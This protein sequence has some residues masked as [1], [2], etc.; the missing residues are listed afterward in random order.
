MNVF[1]SAP[2]FDQARTRQHEEPWKTYAQATEKLARHFLT[3]PLPR[4]DSSRHVSLLEQIRVL[5]K[6]ILTLAGWYR[7]SHDTRFAEHAWFL[8]QEG[9]QWKEWNF[10]HEKFDLST[11]EMAMLLTYALD[12]LE[13]FLSPAQYEQVRA[14]AR[15]RIFQNYLQACPA[16]PAPRVWWYQV[17]TNWN[18][19][20]NGG[21]YCL[22][23]LLRDAPEAAEVMERSAAGLQF[24]IDALP[25]DGACVEG[26]GYWQ[27]GMLYL[28]HT[29][30][31]MEA[32]SGQKHPAFTKPALRAGLIFPFDFSPQDAQIGFGDSN[33]FV[34]AGFLFAVAARTEQPAIVRLLNE[35]IQQRLRRRPVEEFDPFQEYGPDEIFGLLWAAPSSGPSPAPAALTV[36]PSVGWSVFRAQDLTLSF[37][38]GDSSVPHAMRDLCSVNLARNGVVLF[39]YVENWPY[40]LGW[41][42]QYGSELK[43]G[44]HLSR[45]LFPEDNTGVKNSLLI[46]GIGQWQRGPS[47]WGWEKEAVWCDATAFYPWFVQRL[48]RRVSLEPEGFQLTD[49]F[50]CSTESW[51]EIRFHTRGTF[52]QENGEWIVEHNGQS[53]R[54]RFSAETELHFVSTEFTPSVGIRPKWQ[55]LRIMSR[56][57]VPQATLITVIRPG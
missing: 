39:D 57:A 20:C 19:V 14:I 7:I 40:P 51:P 12:W 31:R 10:G 29:L 3:A 50:V 1:P 13:P 42:N 36:Y 46:N 30:F 2:F 25:E 44:R 56:Q 43:P 23:S 17:T 9:L 28:A 47:D 15:V 27:Y 49:E 5:N 55:V 21:A 53:A 35:R 11:G 52:R 4:V 54:L 48:R 41:F 26:I 38:A 22:A 16:E 8:L 18:S 37:R 6:M 33:F 34:A 45:P 24:Y 32:V